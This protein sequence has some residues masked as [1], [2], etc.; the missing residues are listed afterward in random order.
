M[1]HGLSYGT[2]LPALFK[3]AWQLLLDTENSMPDVESRFELAMYE[4]YREPRMSA[5]TTPNSS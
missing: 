5:L 2:L 3:L 1:Q 4:I